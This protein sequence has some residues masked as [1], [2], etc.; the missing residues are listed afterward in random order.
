VPTTTRGLPYPS[1]TDPA[2]GPGQM[3]ALAEAVDSYVIGTYA[4]SAPAVSNWT[5]TGTGTITAVTLTSFTIPSA[6]LQWQLFM[7]FTAQAS[8]TI[9]TLQMVYAGSSF[10]VMAGL[11]AGAVANS[12][13]T[14][15]I[16]ST[17]TKTIGVSAAAAAGVT[18]TKCSY[19]AWAVRI[20]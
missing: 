15:A 9:T 3:Q 12:L 4:G 10:N 8:G 19:M 17:G 14:G 6:W 5:G 18:L 20:G 11:P 13:G 16:G 7:M 1:A 2:N